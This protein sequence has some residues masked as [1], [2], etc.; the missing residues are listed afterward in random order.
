LKTLTLTT[1]DSSIL[2]YLVAAIKND[3]ELPEDQ[4]GKLYSGLSKDGQ[5]IASALLKIK[6]RKEMASAKQRPS[7]PAME[8]ARSLLVWA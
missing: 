7:K 6:K 2:A 1:S 8:T 4:L 3:Q 5:E